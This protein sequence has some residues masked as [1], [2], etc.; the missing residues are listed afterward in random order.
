DISISCGPTK[1]GLDTLSLYDACPIWLNA[2]VHLGQ[3]VKVSPELLFPRDVLE[4]IPRLVREHFLAHGAVDV[5]ALRDMLGTSRKYPVPLLEYLDQIEFT[6]RVG[7]V[8]V[9]A[10]RSDS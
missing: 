9:L 5:A 1:P 10:A 2:L 7:D 4:D 8:R 3:L 6:R